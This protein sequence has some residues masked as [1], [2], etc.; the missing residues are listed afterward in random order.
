VVE[1]PRPTLTWNEVPYATTY[2]VRWA[3]T[4]ANELLPSATWSSVPDETFTLPSDLVYAH[5][6]QW[7]VVAFDAA[8]T[9]LARETSSLYAPGGSETPWTC[10]PAPP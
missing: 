2:A 1:T 7:E 3:D 10:A 6:Y 5:A 9:E 8:G 4:T